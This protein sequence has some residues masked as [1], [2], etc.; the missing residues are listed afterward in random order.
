MSYYAF[1]NGINQVVEVI[2]GRGAD[3]VVDGISDWES[4][5][6]KV[7]GLRCKRTSID[8]AT[9]GFRKNYAGVGFVYDEE[10]DAFIAPPVFPSWVLNRETCQ[11][12]APY[13]R[14]D[15]GKTYGWFEPNRQWIEFTPGE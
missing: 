9:D 1:L 14:P 3:E 5:Y 8:A 10:L 6:E 13:P 11:W 12:E 2:T 4:H 15:D 7:R